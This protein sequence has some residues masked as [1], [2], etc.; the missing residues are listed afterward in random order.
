[1]PAGIDLFDPGLMYEYFHDYCRESAIPFESLLALGRVYSSN[2]QN[3]FRWRW[4]RSACPIATPSAACIERVPA[5]VAGPLAELPEWEIPIT[6]VTNGVHLLSW[7]NGD[8]ALIYDQYLQPDWRERY[9]EASTWE[10][11]RD[12]PSQTCGSAPSPQAPL[13]AFVRNGSPLPPSRGK[14]PWQSCAGCRKCWIPTPS[15]SGSR[16]A[17]LL[18]SALRCCSAT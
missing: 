11:V 17:S 18:T 4:R 9:S 5:D 6:A 8:L 13:I 10:L 15:Q 2:A 3:A 16:A 1:V 14:R 12:I 7:L